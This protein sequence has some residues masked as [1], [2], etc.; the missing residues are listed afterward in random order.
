MTIIKALPK[1]LEYI[2]GSSVACVILEFIIDVLCVFSEEDIRKEAHN[3]LSILMEFID[4]KVM[5][6]E[7]LKVIG[8][9][10]KES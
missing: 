9:L 4:A 8:E 7:L 5:K 10:Q 1:L 6:E 3:T 2:G